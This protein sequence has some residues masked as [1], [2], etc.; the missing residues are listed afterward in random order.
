MRKGYGFV[1]FRAFRGK[2]WC[3]KMFCH[4][5][6]NKSLEGA[7]FCQKCGAKLIREDGAIQPAAI[8]TASPEF[9]NP[10]G[11][12]PTQKKKWPL[13]L[14]PAGAIIAIVVLVVS[15]HGGS[16]SYDPAPISLNTPPPASVA[17]SVSPAQT[18]TNET[19]SANHVAMY[20]FQDSSAVAEVPDFL[21]FVSG[22]NIVTNESNTEIGYV[23]MIT[24]YIQH[25]YDWSDDERRDYFNLLN[26]FGFILDITRDGIYEWK[27]GDI[28]VEAYFNVPGVV[29]IQIIDW[30][31]E[32][33]PGDDWHDD[34]DFAGNNFIDGIFEWV[35]APHYRANST[36]GHF[37]ADWV[38][39]QIG[40]VDEVF[41]NHAIEGVVRNISGR[42]FNY[43]QITFTLFDGSGNQVGSA[44]AQI[45]N[46]GNGNTWRFNAPYFESNVRRFEF[47]GI[48]G[49]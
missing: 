49:F 29:Y 28:L 12:T 42:S 21:Y 45:N 39:G 48:T 2:A 34:Y 8:S 7:E 36:G 38:S 3:I 13:F 15:L 43:V 9:R 17:E 44:H 40:W 23:N 37:A 24:V 18:P 22:G 5:C 20:A 32:D 10:T 26:D 14:I 27:K 19:R 16:G 35:E 31:M 30:G 6:G 4:K 41:L 46:L 47:A 1:P 33:G 11:T 25:D